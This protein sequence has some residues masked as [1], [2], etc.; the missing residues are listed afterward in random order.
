MPFTEE[1]YNRRNWN[2]H[3]KLPY[4][5]YEK[6]KPKKLETGNDIIWEIM[7]GKYKVK[8]DDVKRAI[9]ALD[10]AKNNQEYMSLYWILYKLVNG[11]G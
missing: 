2:K 4:I 7:N 3:G 8:I 6:D 5:T 10:K 9:A 1:I 11:N